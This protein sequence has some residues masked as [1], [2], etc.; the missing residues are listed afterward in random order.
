MCGDHP[1]LTKTELNAKE[2][3]DE[4][5]SSTSYS[6]LSPQPKLN[7]DILTLT[8]TNPRRKKKGVIMSVCG[9][10]ALKPT[11]GWPSVVPH[12]A[13]RAGPRGG[14]GGGAGRGSEPA[15]AEPPRTD[16]RRRPDAPGNGAL[17]QAALGSFRWPPYL[18]AVWVLV[19]V[20]THAL[21]CLVS[22]LERALPRLRQLC[23]YFRNWAESTWKAEHNT[24]RLFPIALAFLTGLLYAFYFAIYTAYS[25]A[26]WSIEPLSTEG[27]SKHPSQEAM[28]TKVTDYVDEHKSDASLKQ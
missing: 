20:L 13:S 24:G 28:E 11:T 12:G 25:I 15:L 16:A 14:S 10:V 7:K 2:P 6:K 9:I 8:L 4:K 3:K 17:V 5:D 22:V 1:S 27:D 23:Q 26:L 18:L 19:L 21:H